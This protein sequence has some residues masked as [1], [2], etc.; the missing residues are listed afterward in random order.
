MEQIAIHGFQ[1]VCNKEADIRQVEHVFLYTDARSYFVNHK[2]FRCQFNHTPFSDVSDILSLT[3]RFYT[4]ERYL[5]HFRHELGNATFF[6]D[7]QP[8]I[9]D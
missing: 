7:E 5:F 1:I 3:H 9:S 6:V 2:S 4:G 8:A